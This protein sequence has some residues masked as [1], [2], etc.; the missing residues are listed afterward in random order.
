MTRIDDARA[1]RR[2]PTDMASGPLQPAE[3]SS[4]DDAGAWH[5]DTLFQP[6]VCLPRARIVGLE[7][8]SRMRSPAGRAIGPMEAFRSAREQGRALELDRLCRFRAIEQFLSMAGRPRELLL[9]L[10]VDASSLADRSGGEPSVCDNIRHFGLPHEN[11]VVEILES[12]IPDTPL[13]VE[14][15]EHCRRSGF[16]IALD[17]IGTGHSNLDRVAQIKPDLLKIDRSLVDRIGEDSYKRSIV[18]SLASLATDVGAL[19]I[20]EGVETERDLRTLVGLGLELYQGFH[21]SKPVRA[22]A[23]S[24]IACDVDLAETMRGATAWKSSQLKGRQAY[25]A[26]LLAIAESMVALLSHARPDE[27][28]DMLE[29]GLSMHAGA[30]CAYILD[31]SGRQQSPTVFAPGCRPR[32]SPLFRPAAPGDDLSLKDYYLHVANGAKQFI[33]EPYVSKATGRLCQTLITP[34]PDGHMDACGKAVF[35]LDMAC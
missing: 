2:N 23:F 31:W 29:R 24:D 28:G 14:F 1:S 4:R 7:A 18:R 35:C 9:F 19:V 20:A 32:R 22:D 13:L 6:I 27:Y 25:A 15:V 16:S 21:F 33:S 30:E 5:V 8:L 17:D 10:N 3:R 34:I 26:H 12:E 11:I